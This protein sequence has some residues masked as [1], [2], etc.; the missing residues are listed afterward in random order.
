MKS[1]GRDAIVNN[2]PVRVFRCTAHCETALEAS[3]KSLVLLKNNGILP[4]KQV[5]KVAVIG[6]NAET[7][8]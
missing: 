1:G 4:L 2:D 6:P 5:K 7:T 8:R 3:R